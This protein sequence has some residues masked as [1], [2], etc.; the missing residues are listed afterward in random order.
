MHSMS[1]VS[2]G[3]RQLGEI[4]HSGEILHSTGGGHLGVCVFVFVCLYFFICV[5]EYNSAL[6]G[7]TAYS[8]RGGVREVPEHTCITSQSKIAFG[9]PAYLSDTVDTFVPAG[10]WNPVVVRIFGLPLDGQ[11]CSSSSQAMFL[12]TFY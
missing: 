10:A 9:S 4:R 6:L 2:E 7:D 8:T 3:K 5:F 1:R 11:L 12:P